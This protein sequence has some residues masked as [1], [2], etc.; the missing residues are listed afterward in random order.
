[1]DVECGDYITKHGK[2]AV[3]QKKVPISQIDRALQNLFSIRIRLG[4]FNGNPAKLK[5]GTIEFIINI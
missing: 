5:Y 1:M 2:S 3:L 4:L